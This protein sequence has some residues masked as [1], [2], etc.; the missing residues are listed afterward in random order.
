M[1]TPIVSAIAL[2]SKDQTRIVIT[3]VGETP[4]LIHEKKD[5]QNLD[6]EEDFRGTRAYRL[7]LASV[8]YDRV[9]RE[10]NQ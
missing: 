1:D 6:P 8:L 5:L 9:T 10:V 3:G 7:H 4:V 2:K